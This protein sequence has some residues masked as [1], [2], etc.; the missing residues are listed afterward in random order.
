MGLFSRTR[1][2][3]EERDA[4][5][6]GTYIPDW[7][8]FTSQMTYSGANVSINSAVGLSAVGAAIRLLAETV[9]Q[10]P[11]NVYKGRGADKRLAD[12][13]WQYQLL[14]EL[15]GAGDFTPFDLISD[16]VG[17]VEANGNAFLQKVKAAGQ[18][19][20]LIVIDPSRVRVV[21]ESGE[22]VFYVRDQN[23]K[24]TRYT[25][26]TIIHIRGFTLTGSDVGLSPITLHRQ[27]LGAILAQDEYLG[28]FYGQGTHSDLAITQPA[29]TRLTDDDAEKFF[30]R[31]RSH[32]AGLANSHMPLLLAPG[33]Q[34]EKLGMS[35]ADAQFVEGEKLNLL[36]VAN[37]FR[38]PG[39]LLG[40]VEPSRL[41]FEQDNLRF[42]TLSVAPRLRRIEMALFSDPDLFP[43][44]IIYPEFDVRALMRTDAKTLADVEHQQIQSGMRQRDEVRADHGLPPLPPQPEDPNESPGQVVP[45]FPVGAGEAAA[46]GNVAN[47]QPESEPADSADTTAQPSAAG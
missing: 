14:A 1:K 23:G 4:F 11:L 36:H 43:Q 37:I 42:Y 29:G 27:K 39:A 46:A 15:P 44:R 8:T 31:W 3:V 30:R 5:T 32:K 34:L 9:A 7:G 40:A 10:L 35:Q 12:Q 6:N 38:I 33:T 17:C 41:G 28:R 13:T 22:K 24:E 18:V 21:R 26:S 25:L 47:N 2:P 19:I 45:M 20:A 16:I